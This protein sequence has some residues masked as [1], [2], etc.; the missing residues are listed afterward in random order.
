MRDIRVSTF[1]HK[2]DM[3]RISQI[4]TYAESVKIREIQR[5]SDG[6]VRPSSS[7][8][9]CAGAHKLVKHK[10]VIRTDRQQ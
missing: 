6:L 8:A 5:L 3:T 7:L 4:N 1:L 10:S 2:E 9:F